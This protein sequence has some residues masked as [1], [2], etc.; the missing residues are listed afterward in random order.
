MKRAFSLLWQIS[1]VDQLLKC[2]VYIFVIL[3]WL[4][5]RCICCKSSQFR[6]LTW[7]WEF[8]CLLIMSLKVR[9]CCTPSAHQWLSSNEGWWR[10]VSLSAECFFSMPIIRWHWILRCRQ[11]SMS[12]SHTRSALMKIRLLMRHIRSLSIRAQYE[13]TALRLN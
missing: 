6:S 2:F 8:C 12:E 7:H 10:T 3:S 13:H 1:T 4:L 11:S 5:H 9:I